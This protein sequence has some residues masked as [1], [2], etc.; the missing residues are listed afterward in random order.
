MPALRHS[1]HREPGITRRRRGRGFSYADARGRPVRD[2]RVLA[3]IHALAI[4][5]AWTDVWICASSRGH[6]QATGTDAAG[7]RQYLYHPS[8]REARDREKHDRV[9]AFRRDLPRLRAR[10]TRDLRPA[11]TGRTRAT[12]A[13]VR[14]IDRTLIRAGEERY[15]AGGGAVGACTLR[16]EHVRVTGESVALCFMGK[17]GK[18]QCTEVRDPLLALALRDLSRLPGDQVFTWRE[19]DDAGVVTPEVVNAYI[20]DAVPGDYTAKDLRTWGATHL[21]ARLFAKLAER[22][23]APRSSRAVA[24]VMREV[25]H[26]L[27]NTPS[28]CRASYVDPRLVDAF[29]DGAPPADLVRLG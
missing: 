12:A 3:R 4:P 9:M 26:A 2:P 28:V 6:L 13:A 14:L 1:H 17:A 16:R 8:W 20:R 15:A 29:L 22:N 25:S 27:G 7:R 18:E 11:V 10:V 24:A 19:G 5:P 23:G 21:A